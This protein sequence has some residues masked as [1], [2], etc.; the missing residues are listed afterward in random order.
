M[1]D[2]A[3]LSYLPTL[4][5]CSVVWDPTAVILISQLES[6][7][8]FRFVTKHW[9]ST[10]DDDLLRWLKWTTLQTR[11]KKQKTMVCRCILCGHSIFTPHPSLNPRRHHSY[12]LATPFARTSEF[13]SSFFIRYTHM[14]NHPPNGIVCA[15]SSFAFK[16]WLIIS[17][18]C[19]QL[20]LHVGYFG[21][22]FLITAHVEVCY[23]FSSIY[24]FSLYCAVVVLR[25]G[26]VS[27]MLLLLYA[28]L[29]NIK[30]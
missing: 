1:A 8:R 22:Y 26:T 27:I 12:L 20:L 29:K 30:I 2:S 10:P 16:H 7:Q 18:H 28:R 6:V 24:Y 15:P 3:C 4:G 5:Y 14:W 11:R 21:L 13:Q 17:N 19:T 23:Y 9:S 25:A